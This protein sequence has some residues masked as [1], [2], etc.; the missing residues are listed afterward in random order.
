MDRRSFT[1]RVLA[2]LGVAALP[3]VEAQPA[4]IPPVEPAPI[5]PVEPAPVPPFARDIFSLN[6]VDIPTMIR[7]EQTRDIEPLVSVFEAH[8]V[9]YHASEPHGEITA[10]YTPELYTALRKAARPGDE[11]E[12]TLHDARHGIIRAT[13]VL[14][15]RR[16]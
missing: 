9:R 6:G 2:A 14:T 1:A 4:P 7:C 5:P 15:V 10:Y 13:G 16:G 12:L 3:P 8:A 11:V